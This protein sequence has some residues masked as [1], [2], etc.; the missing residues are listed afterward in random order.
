MSRHVHL[1]FVQIRKIDDVAY[2]CLKHFG[3]RELENE[4]NMGDPLH[5]IS[6]NDNNL[7]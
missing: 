5:V 1:K 4:S 3:F 2:V 6:E 7:R